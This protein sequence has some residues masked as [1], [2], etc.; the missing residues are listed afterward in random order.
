MRNR[1]WIE[2]I[3]LSV[4]K[5][6]FSHQL[7][8]K[9]MKAVN[10][11]HRDHA[12]S[13]AK[14][15]FVFTTQARFKS[16]NLL[17][18]GTKGNDF[19]TTAVGSDIGSEWTGAEVLITSTAGT[20]H[21]RIVQVGEDDD[22]TYAQNK[23]YID[24]PLANTHGTFAVSGTTVTV[25]RREYSPVT[26]LDGLVP[27][28]LL[29]DVRRRDYGTTG[30]YIV[31][32]DSTD[33]YRNYGTG[34]NVLG[35]ENSELQY[36]MTGLCSRLPAPRFAPVVTATATAGTKTP[37]QL[38]GTMY[39]TC[40]YRDKKS[41]VQGPIGPITKVTI[42]VGAAVGYSL[43]IEYGNES[44]CP[45]QS[46]EL[47]LLTSPLRPVG[48]DNQEPEDKLF[49]INES[50]IPFAVY[51]SHPRDTTTNGAGTKGGG[52]FKPFLVDED[53]F[54]GDRWFPW[55][56]QMIIRFREIPTSDLTYTVPGKTR[57]PWMN[58]IEDEPLIPD[59]YQDAVELAVRSSI[60]G[61]DG[62]MAERRF[63]F[64]L[65]SLRAKD[66]QRLSTTTPRHI[67]YGNEKPQF[68]RYDLG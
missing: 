3:S 48:F 67:R 8:Y 68:D 51:D 15:D 43:S 66:S 2:G 37:D 64:V 57:H 42:P 47:V 35:A 33:F 53:M 17:W 18:T 63:Q 9:L 40:V 30:S 34:S 59:E 23:I 12:W 31:N 7:V 38:G 19:F 50:M 27:D 13:W 36:Y 5:P 26:A 46:Y 45:D 14:R 39:V 61:Q 4:T 58:W 24:N 25:F 22:Q 56:D 52:Q 55:N 28:M 6:Q 44:G 20:D 10:R 16:L 65:R 21:A 49:R 41:G 11:I 62:L 60:A 29:G 1:R 54:A 32:L